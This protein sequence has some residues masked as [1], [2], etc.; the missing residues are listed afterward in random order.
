M[1]TGVDDGTPVSP[2][3][4]SAGSV[5]GSGSLPLLL[6][7]AASR[8]VVLVLALSSRP[9]FVLFNDTNLLWAW[10]N[11][12]P[13]G[14]DP[15]PELGEYP[16]AARLLALTGRLAPTAQV[17][18]WG[19]IAAML[20]VDLAMLL[21]LA[22]AGRRGAWLWVVAGAALGP[23]MWLRFDLLV[24]LLAASAVVQRGRR[25]GLSGVLW[26]LAVLLKLWPLVLAAALLPRRGWQRW[27]SAAAGTV[28]A[29]LAVEALVAGPAA[30]STPLTYQAGRGLQ[31]E[32]LPASVLLWQRRGDE[33]SEVL[34]FAYRAYQL[35][36]TASAP[37]TLVG[38]VVLGS[39]GLAV[40]V[41]ASR[42][43]RPVLDEVR[44]LA[45]ALLSVLV[46]A[47]N[48]VFSPQYVMW[49]LPLVALVV[50]LSRG[51]DRGAALL[52]V[53]ATG[54]AAL[55]QRIW[56]WRYPE[57]LDLD[58]GTVGAL[59]LR[60]TL[61]VVLAVVLGLRLVGVLRQ[62]GTNVSLT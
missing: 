1:T 60:N 41:A 35:Q 61:V 17:F 21:V 56:P 54:I 50:G 9:S 2:A 6:A 33:P 40:L 24:A 62:P 46:V 51:A 42:C 4:T 53:V 43:A 8:A 38:V 16:G 58:P 44:T 45:A 20:L 31:I 55:T 14:D 19:W 7:W 26:G 52:A 49:F 25:P 22:G 57:L 10:A 5:R 13:F 37:A 3:Q 12:V 23:V 30:L 34:E 48:A 28:G 29:G 59:L 18:G 47:T 11:G 27:A 39:V 32:S 36:D 15:S